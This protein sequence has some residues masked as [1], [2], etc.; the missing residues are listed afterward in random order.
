MSAVT[1]GADRRHACAAWP[2]SRRGTRS[3]C[4][5]ASV[6]VGRDRRPGGRPTTLRRA[7]AGGPGPG[8]VRPER[9]GGTGPSRRRP[10][11]R[12]ATQAYQVTDR[13][14]GGRHVE[15]PPYR[16]IGCGQGEQMD[17]RAPGTPAPGCG[18]S[19]G[20]MTDKVPPL[21]SQSSGQPAWRPARCPRPRSQQNSVLCQG[22]QRDLARNS[23]PLG[24]GR[25]RFSR[26]L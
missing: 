18:R 2:G 15:A 17:A 25:N 8:D 11:P 13:T 12:C 5:S 20:A 24:L 26:P 6:T 4:R 21:A 1:R 10:R 7:P 22:L 14:Y 16:H 19:P 23:G 3:G 9:C